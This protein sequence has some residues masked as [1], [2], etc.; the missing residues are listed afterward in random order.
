MRR[1][2]SLTLDSAYRL[3]KISGKVPGTWRL[4]TPEAANTVRVTMRD[5]EMYCAIEALA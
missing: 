2:P 1:V 5:G 3:A 4:D